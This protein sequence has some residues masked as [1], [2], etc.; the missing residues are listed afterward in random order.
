MRGKQKL[1]S[2]S[3]VSSFFEPQYL[4]DIFTP[5]KDARAPQTG[6]IVSHRLAYHI[7]PFPNMRRVVKPPVGS[8]SFASSQDESGAYKM[9]SG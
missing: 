7:N 9:R 6:Q 8:V 4:Q 1:N 3:N 2:A 5:P